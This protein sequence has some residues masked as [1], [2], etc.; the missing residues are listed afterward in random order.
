M[1]ADMRMTM[2]PAPHLA[3]TCVRH[4]RATR[5]IRACGLLPGERLALCRRTGGKATAG[6]II[7]SAL[8]GGWVLLGGRPMPGGCRR[9]RGPNR[10]Q[11][12]SVSRGSAMTTTSPPAER[13]TKPA[14]EPLPAGRSLRRRRAAACASARQRRG[15]AGRA[16][17]AARSTQPIPSGACRRVGLHPDRAYWSGFRPDTAMRASPFRPPWLTPDRG[18]FVC[19]A[20]ATPNSR[21]S[22]S[23]SCPAPRRAA[24]AT[25]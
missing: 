16:T 15:A 4:L 9:D 5:A 8:G 6:L 17:A 21:C 25:S 1:V 7:L 24:G 2:A 23:A 20:S 13:M 10:R 11:G 12:G 22:R 18:V 19:R 14:I 3:M